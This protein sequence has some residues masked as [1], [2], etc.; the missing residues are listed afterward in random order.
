MNGVSNLFYKSGRLGRR[1]VGRGAARLAVAIGA[2]LCVAGCGTLVELPGSGP[3]P[4]IFDLS[5]T[6]KPALASAEG[7]WRLFVDEPDAPR[8][9]DTDKVVLRRSGV[10]LQY[11]KGARWSD[12]APKLL[13][14]MLVEA[15][16]GSGAPELVSGDAAIARSRYVLKGNLRSFEAQYDSGGAPLVVVRLKLM[17]SDQLSGK[18]ISV[19]SFES[20]TQA[21]ADRL[22]DIVR[23]MNVSAN[24]V[25]TEAAPWIIAAMSEV[26]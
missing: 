10:E 12:R 6:A 22:S 4:R 19:R 7:K 9:L 1:R 20:S 23:A 11:Y 15:L 14:A 26:E 2:A 13:Q 21:S 3:A 5:V 17:L 25:V 16:D 18:L 24:A 8:A